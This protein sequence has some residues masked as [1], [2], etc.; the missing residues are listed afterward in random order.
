MGNPDLRCVSISPCR[1]NFANF[2]A[3]AFA[4]FFVSLFGVAKR[5]PG[6]KSRYKERIET[7]IGYAETIESWD[8]LVDP[9]SLAFYNLGPDPSPFVLRHL[10]IEGKKSKF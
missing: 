4:N 8:E 7:A 9:R 10:G 5:R 3:L 6:L 2:E 1:F